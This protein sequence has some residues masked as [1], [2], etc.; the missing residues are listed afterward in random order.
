MSCRGGEGVEQILA[1]N[2]GMTE[3]IVE[4]G[5]KSSL[6]FFSAV[7][8]CLMLQIEGQKINPPK[9]LAMTCRSKRRGHLLDQ[10]FQDG[11]FLLRKHGGREVDSCF[12][13]GMSR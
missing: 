6:T 4:V 3:K 8:R 13:C 9:S 1:V 10:G 5:A 7:K 11:Q 12:L 2:I